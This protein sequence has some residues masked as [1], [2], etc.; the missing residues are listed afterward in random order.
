[1]DVSEMCA[2]CLIFN[3][4]KDGIFGVQ[5][6]EHR[7]W[8]EAASTKQESLVIQFKWISETINRILH[9]E[10]TLHQRPILF[11]EQRIIIMLVPIDL[12]FIICAIVLAGKGR[13]YNAKAKA[14]APKSDFGRL[15][16]REKSIWSTCLRCSKR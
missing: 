14:I 9:K 3:A 6:D 13:V 1:M 4:K 12:W 11:R 8:P 2:I 5:W 7:P 15:K 16:D 10:T